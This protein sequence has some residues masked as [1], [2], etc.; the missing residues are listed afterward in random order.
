MMN[1]FWWG[2]RKGRTRGIDW[3]KWEWLTPRKGYGGLGFRDLTCFNLAMLGKLGW[4][5]ITKPDATVSRIFKVRYYPSR[6]FLEAN[7]GHNPSF[8]WCSIR[9]S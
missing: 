2:S 5:L 7:M 4:K 6:D 9:S 8:I 1:S 3:L